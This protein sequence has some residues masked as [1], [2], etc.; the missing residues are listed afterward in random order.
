MTEEEENNIISVVVVIKAAIDVV[1]VVVEPASLNVTD[2]VVVFVLVPQ[3]SSNA[4]WVLASI[5][6]DETSELNEEKVDLWDRSAAA[7]C[8][9]KTTWMVSL[10][11]ILWCPS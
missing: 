4:G 9:S 1:T 6:L 8:Y 11:D 2:N 3:H 5:E 7:G 10:F